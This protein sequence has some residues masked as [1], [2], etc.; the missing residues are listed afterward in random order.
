MKTN[1]KIFLI[2]AIA[3]ALLVLTVILSHAQPN[4]NFNTMRLK[5]GNDTTSFSPQPNGTLMY[6]NNGKLLFKTSAYWME[7]AQVTPGVYPYWKTA[8]ATVLTSPTITGT[9]KQIGNDTLRG[10]FIHY[11][12]DS[13]TGSFLHGG[14]TTQTGNIALTGNLTG[15]GDITRTGNIALTGNLT[16]TGDITRTG[17]IALT[18]N[19]TGTGTIDRAG[20]LTIDIKNTNSI[21]K[22]KTYGGL[23]IGDNTALGGVGGTSIYGPSGTYQN[24]ITGDT[25]VTNNYGW[26]NVATAGVTQTVKTAGVSAQTILNSTSYTMLGATIKPAQGTT[27]LAPITFTAGTN[28]TTP[29]SGTM[30]FDGTEWYITSS[31]TRYTLPRMLVFTDTFDMASITNGTCGNRNVTA[32]GAAVGD[33]VEVGLDIATPYTTAGVVVKPYVSA[34]NQVSISICNNSGSAYDPANTNAKIKVIK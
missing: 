1:L 6:G 15:T 12:I 30:E 27:T 13:L 24:I 4:G 23:R 31:T 3:V 7:L 20:T 32:S 8:G 22:G 2:N 29:V 21:I 14:N 10:D 17:N 33:I 18:G 34:T 19:L 16:G 11:G 5:A 26:L 9:F 28:L 25:T